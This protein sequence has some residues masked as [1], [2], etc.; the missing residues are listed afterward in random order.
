MKNAPPLREQVLA[1]KLHSMLASV[2]ACW[3]ALSPLELSGLV[4][5]IIFFI[6]HKAE[7]NSRVPTLS[8]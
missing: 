2:Q 5:A 8:S 6:A 1:H 4:Q 3:T 7:G